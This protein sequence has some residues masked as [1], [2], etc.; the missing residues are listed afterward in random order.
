MKKMYLQVITDKQEVHI[1]SFLLLYFIKFLL[2]WSY[3]KNL[4]QTAV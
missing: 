1:Y 4:D 2:I 3:L